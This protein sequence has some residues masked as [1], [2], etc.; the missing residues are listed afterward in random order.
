MLRMYQEAM[1][2]TLLLVMSVMQH[3]P[4]M[5]LDDM[6]YPPHG[7]SRGRRGAMFKPNNA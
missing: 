6:H 3:H 2:D 1:V 5:V 4:A 7:L